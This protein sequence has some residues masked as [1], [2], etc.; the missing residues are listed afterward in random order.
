[1]LETMKKEIVEHLEKAKETGKMSAEEIERIVEDAV[2]KAA[3]SAKEG[4]DMGRA[5]FA[6]FEGCMVYQRRGIMTGM[7]IQGQMNL[8]KSARTANS[9]ALAGM[10]ARKNSPVVNCLLS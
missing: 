1:M 4:R 10:P 2:A 6:R 9:S 5:L 3:Q 7:P 8:T